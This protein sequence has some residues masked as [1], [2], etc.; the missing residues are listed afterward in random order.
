MKVLRNGILYILKP[1]GTVYSGTGKKVNDLTPQ[2]RF[3]IFMIC[4]YAAVYVFFMVY[5]ACRRC[6]TLASVFLCTK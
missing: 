4:V 3:W 5:V 1:D 2:L 6:E